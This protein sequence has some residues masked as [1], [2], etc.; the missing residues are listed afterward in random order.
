ML[1]IALL[2]LAAVTAT[3]LEG[4]DS[5]VVSGGY[6]DDVDEGDVIIYTGDGGRD[7]LSRKQVRDQ[8]FSGFNRAL[9]LSGDRRLP[10]RVVRGA[11]AESKYA[12]ASGYR[13]DGLFRVDDYWTQPG[14]SG[15][16]VWTY[17]LVKVE[18]EA[19]PEIAPSPSGSKAPERVEQTTVRVIRDTKIGRWI[20]RVHRYRCQ[21]CGEALRLPS[22]EYAEAAHIRPLGRPHNGPDTADNILCLCPNHHVLFDRGAFS[23]GNDL[24][25]IGA[26]GRLRTVKEHPLN[27]DYLEYHRRHYRQGE[28]ST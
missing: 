8:E 21:V 13:Y 15:F 19:E 7:P 16:M 11:S 5:I 4:A 28:S 2:G 18:E 6:E 1:P 26:D 23:V 22:G 27:A 12:P 17:R 9:A 25:L 3:V 24:T 20:K 10:V 14:K